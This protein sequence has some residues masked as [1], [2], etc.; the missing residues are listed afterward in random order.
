MSFSIAD[1]D[2]G[3]VA[4]A[5]GDDSSENEMT[6]VFHLLQ[7]VA[8]QVYCNKN[9]KQTQSLLEIT[10]YLKQ[11]SNAN[12]TSKSSSDNE[13][14]GSVDGNNNESDANANDHDHANSQVID[15]TTDDFYSH[16]K[17]NM[18]LRNNVTVSV[19]AL[20][21]FAGVNT[22]AQRLQQFFKDTLKYLQTH[23]D[24]IESVK[25]SN[26]AKDALIEAKNAQKTFRTQVIGFGIL[27][28]FGFT[29]ILI[30]ACG[31]GG[32]LAAAYAYQVICNSSKATAWMMN[33]VL[34]TRCGIDF[35]DS[36][37]G[38]IKTFLLTALPFVIPEYVFNFTSM[39]A[40]R[41]SGIT[42]PYVLNFGLVV[43][44]AT[45]YL[46]AIMSGEYPSSGDWIALFGIALSMIIGAAYA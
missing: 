32:A 15:L 22:N 36:T 20:Q 34:R 35:G 6:K 27:G 21:V 33:N 46:F 2:D 18:S 25:H 43:D 1:E 17:G 45:Q 38:L 14:N 42:I 10:T 41:S 26:S 31:W 9:L 8:T 23:G 7:N 39:D 24:S 5:M 30:V 40:A 4:I 28:F 19:A 37:N 11:V 29:S 13:K 44:K 3:D 16:V 12:K